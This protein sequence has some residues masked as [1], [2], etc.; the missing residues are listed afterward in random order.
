[1][2]TSSE[3]EL[4]DAVRTRMVLAL[5]ALLSSCDSARI[6]VKERL[7]DLVEAAEAETTSSSVEAALLRF[8]SKLPEY[9]IA[10]S[11]N[12]NWRLFELAELKL[13]TRRDRHVRIATVN[14]LG[15]SICI[16]G[17]D[18]KLKTKVLAALGKMIQVSRLV[19]S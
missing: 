1:M 4:E 13:R 16:G 17:A 12:M 10:A 5:G 8:F 7:V 3:R 14:L 6:I 2:L 18:G 9:G 19:R 15:A 11:K